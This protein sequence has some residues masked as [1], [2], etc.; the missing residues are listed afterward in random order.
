MYPANLKLKSELKAPAS[1]R[2]EELIKML[3]AQIKPPQS[4]TAEEV[5]IR[6][7]YLVSDAIN[8]YGGCFP[9][10]S[11]EQVKNLVIDSP[12]LVGHQKDQLPIA[13]NFHAELE[14][15]D[16]RLWV[17]TYFYWLAKGDKAEELLRQI[18]G[19]IYK[20][21]SIGFTFLLPECSICQKDIR[22]CRHNP[23]EEY[24]IG[25]QKK[26]CYFYYKEI[27]RVLETSLVY[28]GANPDT[29]I[30]D[31]LDAHQTKISRLDHLNQLD[32]MG[33]FLVM[34]AYDGLLIDLNKPEID[35][36]KINLEQIKTEFD[37]SSQQS[38]VGVLI[39]YRGK[40]R[41]S[42][43]QLLKY[44][45]G[46]KGSIK[47]LEFRYLPLIERPFKTDFNTEHIKPIR[48][49]LVRFEQLANAIAQVKTKEGVM[50]LSLSQS[51]RG[52]LYFYQP[53]DKADEST[54]SLAQLQHS[55]NCLLTINQK[56]S[57]LRF[58]FKNFKLN[59]LLSGKRL[60]AIKT[61]EQMELKCSSILSGQLTD[62]NINHAS[63]SVRMNGDINGMLSFKPLRFRGEEIFYLFQMSES[64]K[65]EAAYVG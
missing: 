61:N 29:S 2:I 12:V 55:N 33:N 54:F 13:R 47:H 62:L 11:L 64:K 23:L 60:I 14:Q 52:E 59:D 6:V 49:Q 15:K 27:D 5:N 34:P 28:R 4:L 46:K 20:E 3:N 16:D 22:S 9:G 53:D 17:K 40:E 43:K 39:G 7:M 25:A 31:R 37:F 8:S 63:P 44:L 65:M 24:R 36:S 18:D 32:R 48:Y 38:L 42:Q 10:E 1:N 30:S 19:G 41:C 57:R 21:C 51:Q 56:D 26:L 35:S 50:I 58:L 45:D